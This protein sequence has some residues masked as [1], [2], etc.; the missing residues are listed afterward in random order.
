MDVVWSTHYP[1]L[2]RLCLGGR[3]EGRIAEVARE[4][5][6]WIRGGWGESGA[7]PAVVGG[8]GAGLRGVGSARRA[9][10]VRGRRGVGRGPGRVPELGLSALH[11]GRLVG[12]AFS[13]LRLERVQSSTRRPHPRL[14]LRTRV[15]PSLPSPLSASASFLPS[16]PEATW[17]ARELSRTRL[18]SP[19]CS[20]VSLGFQE[21]PSSSFA[22][23]T[24]FLRASTPCFRPLKIV[25][26]VLPTRS[27]SSGV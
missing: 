21:L 11:P 9:E 8:C 22:F 3:E 18:G 14:Q 20:R 7:V 24:Q 6:H 4:R 23:T 5:S 15:P 19:V 1:Q 16:L 27:S 2:A 25:G 13:G 17:L 26:R 10:L 12:L